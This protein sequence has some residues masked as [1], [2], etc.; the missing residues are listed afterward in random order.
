LIF[1]FNIIC[2]TISKKGDIT[3]NNVLTLRN[4]LS[5]TQDEFAEFCN[6]SRISIA[7]YEAGTE[8]H[9][10]NA[11]KI[12]SACGVPVEYVLGIEQNDEPNYDAEA[13]AIRER[14]R[15][16]P[17]Y[18]LLFDAAGNATPDH[19]RAAAAMLKALEPTGDAEID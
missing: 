1:I 6:V 8:I 18:R 15:R 4:R 11:M 10:A 7:R 2:D 16:D 19:L 9:R 5:M 17:A 13:V 14:L 3:M 12:A